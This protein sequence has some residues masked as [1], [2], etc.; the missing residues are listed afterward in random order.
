MMRFK[1]GPAAGVTLSCHGRTPL[2]LRVVQ[3]SR[4][5]W[6]ALNEIED[7]PK[8]D[9]RIYVYIIASPPG[10]MH[11]SYRPRSRSYSGST[12]EYK[13]WPEQ[14]A[15]AHVRGNKA[16]QA[17]CAANHGAIIPRLPA[18]ITLNA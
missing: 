15:E 17:W 3:N 13:L 12:S 14:P 10:W 16:W 4:G 11:V 6:D 8:P 7:T 2:M 9:E 18:G 1:D 5:E